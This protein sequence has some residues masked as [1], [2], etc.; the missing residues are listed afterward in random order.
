MNHTYHDKIQKNFE[1]KFGED[2]SKIINSVIILKD[3]KKLILNIDSHIYMINTEKYITEDE[4]DTKYPI[5]SMNILDDKRTILIS[6][7]NS[8]SMLQ[9]ESNKLRIKE[10]ISDINIEYPGIIINYLDEFAWTCGRYI[11]FSNGENFEILK[12]NIILL[13]V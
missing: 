5:I 3:Q 6:H 13:V 4:I 9:I 8:I 1:I 7:S 11:G 12:K 2:S 10:F